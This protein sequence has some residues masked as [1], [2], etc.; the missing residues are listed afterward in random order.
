MS[1]NFRY[2]AIKRELLIISRSSLFHVHIHYIYNNFAKQ[3]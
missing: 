3:V 2:I 1:L